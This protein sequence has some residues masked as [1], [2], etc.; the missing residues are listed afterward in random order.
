MVAVTICVVQITIHARLLPLASSFKNFMQAVGLFLTA[1]V[2]FSGMTL[3]YLILAMDKAVLT[4]DEERVLDLKAK[5]RGLKT[6]MEVLVFG[7]VALTCI[8]VV[9]RTRHYVIK[10]GPRILVRIGNKCKCRCRTMKRY[11]AAQTIKK[12]RKR[13]E[14]AE[15]EEQDDLDEQEE[16]ERDGEAGG[17]IEMSVVVVRDDDGGQQSDVE[18]KGAGTGQ[19]STRNV[20]S[21]RLEKPTVDGA[22][23]GAEDVVAALT[24]KGSFFSKLGGTVAHNPLHKKRSSMEAIAPDLDSLWHN[25]GVGTTTGESKGSDGDEVTRDGISA[26]NQEFFQHQRKEKEC[27]DAAAAQ[28]TPDTQYDNPMMHHQQQ[29]QRQQRMAAAVDSYDVFDTGAEKTVTPG[30]G[31]NMQYGNPMMQQQ[32]QQA[33]QG[34]EV[35]E[36]AEEER[37]RAKNLMIREQTRTYKAAG[38]RRQGVAFGGGVQPLNVGT[39]AR[40]TSVVLE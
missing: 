38:G 5:I 17:S 35:A 23:G 30:G 33:R 18:E 32:Q 16:Q 28:E 15:A 39:V 40:N 8:A 29:R 34:A 22:A 20:R 14:E 4:Y 3:N 26:R 19:G 13:K 2:S 9:T 1:V 6:V 12:K 37:G 21:K 36:T 27:A 31:N 25:P 11:V 24:S 10:Y 7:G